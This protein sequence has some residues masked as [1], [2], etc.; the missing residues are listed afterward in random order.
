MSFYRNIVCKNVSC[1]M[2]LNQQSEHAQTSIL[3]QHQRAAVN[4]INVK[5]ARFSYERLFSSY[6][7]ALN[8]LSYEKFVHLMLMKLTP[9]VKFTNNLWAAFVR[10]ILE[11]INDEQ[12]L[13]QIRM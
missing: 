2:G 6:V 3:Q 9:R 10:I 13:A 1:D 5:R 11:P 4:F 7:L 12:F 8:K